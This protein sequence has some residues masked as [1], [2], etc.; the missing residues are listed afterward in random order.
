MSVSEGT[1]SNL[2]PFMHIVHTHEFNIAMATLSHNMRFIL[3]II[4]FVVVSTQLVF[5][6]WPPGMKALPGLN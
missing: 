1:G 4:L 5:S 6:P 2:V 3:S